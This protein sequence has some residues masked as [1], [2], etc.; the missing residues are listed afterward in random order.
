MASTAVTPVIYL[1]RGANRLLCG[2]AAKP[3]L[4]CQLRSCSSDHRVGDCADLLLGH[5]TAGGHDGVPE[6]PEADALIR[7]RGGHK[8]AIAHALIAQV[9]FG[10]RI[11]A[12]GVRIGELVRVQL[13][14]R[15]GLLS[16]TEDGLP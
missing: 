3:D 10:R 1:H 2:A 12:V 14:R 16:R 8:A 6:T 7:A 11:K 5:R 15:V 13:E 4:V 9:G